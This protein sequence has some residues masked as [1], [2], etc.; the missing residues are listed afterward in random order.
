MK[1]QIFRHWVKRLLIIF[2]IILPLVG[3]GISAPET[4]EPAGVEEVSSDKERVSA[5]DVPEE[6]ITVL[7]DG[8]LAF[9]LDLYHQVKAKD[10]NLFYSPYSISVALAMTYAGARGETAQQMAETLHYDLPQEKLHPAFNALDQILA[11]RGEEELPEDS[12][13]P[14]QLSIANALWG[15][16]D[17]HFEQ[18]FLDTVAENYGAGLRLLNFLEKAE[19][20]RQ[21]INQ[22]VYEKT[23]GKIEDLIPKGGVGAATR[24]V[25]TNAIYFN[26]SW[27]E[28]FPQDRTEDGPFH[29]LEGETVTVPMMS[30]ASPQ[31]FRYQDGS[32]Y[33][34]VELPY[35]GHKVSMLVIVPDE[36]AFG[37][38]E[39]GLSLE[40]MQEILGNLEGQAVSLT[41]PKYEFESELSLARILAEMGMPAAMSGEADF[42]GMTGSKDLFISDVFHKAFVSVDEE[43]TEAAAATAVVMTE[44]AMP[45][46]PVEL[47]VDRP[48]FFLI[49]DNETGAV[50]FFG[51]VLN[52]AE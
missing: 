50:L 5:P 7:T 6:D 10:E 27:L 26:A 1:N 38:F 52:P 48:F 34:V 33:Q 45:A 44:S 9:A 37:S 28:K 39:E 14:F 35:V 47:T 36:G 21:T 51:R 12:G 30:Y 8:N 42:S 31:N 40:K 11:S 2:T 23:E 43:G 18:A 32:N 17:Y 49:R 46:S 25:L 29:T 24:L 15:Q 3:C 22:W 19:E 16:K 41:F 4:G 20:A 13:D